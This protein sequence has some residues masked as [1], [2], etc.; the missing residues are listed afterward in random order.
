[1]L[2]LFVIALIAGVVAGISPCILPV[3][4]VVLA[5]GATDAAP[6]PAGGSGRSGRPLAVV[7]GLALSFALF[8]LVGSALLSALGLPQDLIRDLGIVVLAAVGAGLLVPRLG[9]A[10]E[11]PFI[12]L[13]PSRLPG[14]LGGFAL[15]L[16]L[17]AVYVP[18]AGP[19]LAAISVIAATRRFGPAGIAV[20]LLF[21]VGT[22]A[23]LLVV[24]LAGR[25]LSERVRALRARAPTVRVVSGVI[26]L[27]MAALIASGATNRLAA[28]VPGYT[29][30]LQ[31]AVEGGSAVRTA[32]AALDGEHA[33]TAP[34]ATVAADGTLSD[35]QP[36]VPV[37]ALCGLAPNFVGITAWLNTPHGE[38]L[39]MG[40]LRGQVVLVDFWTYSCINCERALPHV[41]AWYRRYHP[42]GLEVVGVHT[43]EFAFEH[44]VANVRVAARTLKVDYP[45]AI[46][47]RYATW[48]AY[49]N[50]YWPADYLIDAQGVIRYVAFGEGGYG[51]TESLIR[52]L[53]RAA[54]PGLR[55]PPRTDVPNLTPTGP[56]TPETYL[57]YERDDS[58]VQT[59]VPNAAHRYTMPAAVRPNGVGLGGV[60]TAGGEELTAGAAA[61]LRLD[62]QAEDVYLVAGGRG[63]IE[64]RL[65]NG[66][67]RTIRVG[68]IPRLYTL[69]KGHAR[70]EGLLRLRL[71]PGI[72][73]YDITFG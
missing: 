14:R 47:D 55:L 29:S 71:T 4:P 59:L 52:E 15:G 63:K 18:C 38:P 73:A 19:V 6:T 46:D 64:V 25:G 67:P 54:H 65:G 7:L 27:A 28:A 24:A 13:G 58:L 5:A 36:N 61:R 69:L 70:T 66:A 37:L 23:P 51:A 11:R 2:E 9:T 16:A 8:T 17:G 50:E 62:F 35:C 49:D 40:G 60:W 57:G 30:A 68:G 3:L 56:M 39:T 21:A 1:M 31:G 22:A 45:I 34:V 26:L 10:L 41:E 43:P 42:Y 48:D 20:T 72:Q 32:L 53:L 12:R 33:P 44:V